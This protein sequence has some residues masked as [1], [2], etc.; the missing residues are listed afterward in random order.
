MA[1]FFSF[2]VLKYWNRISVVQAA[3]DALDQV[4]RPLDEEGSECLPFESCPLPG[5]GS[6]GLKLGDYH[7]DDSMMVPEIDETLRGDFPFFNQLLR[8]P[9]SKKEF[10]FFFLGSP[11]GSFN[12][13]TGMLE[14][15]CRP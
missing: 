6:R 12:I 13:G 3:R 15:G 11:G 10:L 8:V 14:V 5:H 7:L 2:S 1:H 4:A 9:K